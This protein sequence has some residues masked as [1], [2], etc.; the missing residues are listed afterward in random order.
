MMLSIKFC[1]GAGCQEPASIVFHPDCL[2]FIGAP[3][4]KRYNEE[5]GVADVR[6]SQRRRLEAGMNALANGVAKG[7]VPFEEGM[8]ILQ[9]L[10]EEVL[11]MIL[12]NLDHNELVKTGLVSKRFND[13][14]WKV[15]PFVV[16]KN[17]PE[18][19][20][21]RRRL[22]DS[23]FQEAV[24]NK[25]LL[26][27]ERTAKESQKD[28]EMLAVLS[29]RLQ[30]LVPDKTYERKQITYPVNGTF[31]GLETDTEEEREIANITDPIERAIRKLD[32]YTQR[33]S[34]R[35]LTNA[36]IP[37]IHFYE[38]QAFEDLDTAE[39]LRQLKNLILRS[40]G[41]NVATAR[42]MVAYLPK[43]IDRGDADPGMLL[44]L[45]TLMPYSE[46]IVRYLKGTFAYLV[47]Y[48]STTHRDVLL[49]SLKP[50]QEHLLFRMEAPESD[51][52]LLED[53]YFYYY[54]TTKALGKEPLPLEH[55]SELPRVRTTN[56]N[57]PI[58]SDMLSLLRRTA[59]T[60]VQSWRAGTLKDFGPNYISTQ[61][62]ADEVVSQVTKKVEDVESRTNLLITM[63]TVGLDMLHGPVC[64]A[65]V[66]YSRLHGDMDLSNAMAHPILEFTRASRRIS[67]SVR[68]ISRAMR[69][70]P[71]PGWT[72]PVVSTAREARILWLHMYD[73]FP[74]HA[75]TVYLNDDDVGDE[76]TR[77]QDRHINIVLEVF[78]DHSHARVVKRRLYDRI[79]VWSYWN[80]WQNMRFR[81]ED[82]VLEDVGI[83]GLD[84]YFPTDL[85]QE[86]GK[87][88]MSEDFVVMAVMWLRVLVRGPTWLLQYYIDRLEN[89]APCHEGVHNILTFSTYWVLEM[90]SLARLP[91][92][93]RLRQFPWTDSNI[94]QYRDDPRFNVKEIMG[95]KL[96]AVPRA[97]YRRTA[98]VNYITGVP[99]IILNQDKKYDWTRVAAGKAFR[100]L[101]KRARLRDLQNQASAV[102]DANAREQK[103]QEI[104]RVLALDVETFDGSETDEFQDLPDPVRERLR[105]YVQ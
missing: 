97:N 90:T 79:P 40:G 34:L 45:V 65:L 31:A 103:Q 77:E 55:F 80:S 54:T 48:L 50:L 93:M 35:Q 39:F 28:P 23:L 63:L 59:D 8:S 61:A 66:K 13:L 94:Y 86:A 19:K 64:G 84:K 76:P 98:F 25:V 58:D 17:T 52:D 20:I 30:K 44:T 78:L 7:T 32:F 67:H 105:P 21:L 74:W 47:E 99:E 72:D 53:A 14:M 100:T 57:P 22:L 82:Y 60:I 75:T 85:Y 92:V 6:P 29:E 70:F 38:P 87:L 69:R 37:Q 33:A 68:E 24:R 71:R 16:V 5:M 41:T 73:I 56:E 26:A 42:E 88:V 12:A 89:I 10:P 95:S 18:S 104:V 101:A 1:E 4:S 102:Q 83:A 81:M 15:L 62:A 2:D 43:V 9:G 46:S 11:I 96:F 49:Q 91:N 36:Q 51:E 3:A 27:I